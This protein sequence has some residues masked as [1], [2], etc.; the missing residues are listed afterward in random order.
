M[1]INLRSINT[2]IRAEDKIKSDMYGTIEKNNGPAWIGF[3]VGVASGSLTIATRVS[4]IFEALAK[5]SVNIVGSPFSK[6]CSFQRGVKQFLLYSSKSII[7][8][9]F[10]AFSA[11][12]GL[13]T[14]TLKF[15]TAPKEHAA[16]LEKKHNPEREINKWLD[17]YFETLRTQTADCSTER[18]AQSLIKTMRPKLASQYNRL[19]SLER[20]FGNKKKEILYKEIAQ[21][22][23]EGPNLILTLVKNILRLKPAPVEKA[24][25]TELEVLHL[26]LLLNELDGPL[27]ELETYDKIKIEKLINKI[28]V[29]G[30]LDKKHIRNLRGCTETIGKRKEDER[31][32]AIY[33]RLTTIRG[34]YDS[35]TKD[36]S[37]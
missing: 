12:T 23:T 30:N 28:K 34:I 6:E 13:F 8:L 16:I 37:E 11:I 14:K 22:C 31:Y 26:E 19:S 25:I 29:E 9:P 7:I 24:T 10:S 4:S 3:F 27:Q 2:C 18:K 32:S 33:A 15:A 20:D 1:K 36:E 5:G 35:I 21:A 17:T